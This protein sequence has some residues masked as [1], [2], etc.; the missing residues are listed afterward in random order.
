MASG[1]LAKKGTS[2]EYVRSLETW[3]ME[4]LTNGKDSKNPY[5][6]ESV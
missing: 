3:R 1:P 4:E 5:T 2:A 6:P